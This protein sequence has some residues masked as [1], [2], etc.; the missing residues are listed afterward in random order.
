[1]FQGYQPRLLFIGFAIIYHC[2]YMKCELKV[3]GMRCG[4]CELL[5]TEAL[6]EVDG[7]EKAEASH[8]A[9][10]VS[11]FYDPSKVTVEIIKTVIE[12]QGFSVKG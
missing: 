8:E 10:S 5:V 7:V 9:G 3:S 2:V 11:V 1:M 12:E 4:G 6:G